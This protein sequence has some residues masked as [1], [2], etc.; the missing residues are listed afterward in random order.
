[1]NELN[2]FLIALGGG[3]FG[4]ITLCVN[5]YL[6]ICSKVK[7]YSVAIKYVRDVE[8]IRHL[9]DEIAILKRQINTIKS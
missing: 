6:L 5:Y 4:G 3:I 9:E 8:N 7:Q 1:M 2:V